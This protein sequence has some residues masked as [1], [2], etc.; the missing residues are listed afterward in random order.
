MP[1]TLE[2]PLAIGQG[3]SPLLVTV[4]AIATGALVANLYYAQPLIASIAPELGIGP[5]LAGSIVSV[6]QIGYGLGLFL[7]VSLADLIENKT[8]V[9]V[10]LACTTLGLIGAALSTATVPFFVAAFLI[11]LCSTGAQVLIPFMAHLV[12]IERR[13]RMVGNV[14]AGLLTGIMLARPVA[15]F[16]AASFGWRAVFWSSAV[17]M[18]AIGAALARLM[19]T[20]KPESRM[21]Y[22]QIL[23]SMAGLLR[24]LP[25]LR[26]R[27]VYQALMFAAFNMFWTAAPLMLAERFGLGEYG[28]GLFALAGA[29]GALAAPLAGRFADSGHMRA[30]TAGA[31]IMLGLGFLA[32]GWAAAAA[33]LGT[34]AVLAI[35]IDAAVQ[36]NQVVSQRIIF[37]VPSEVRGRVNA[38]YMTATFIGGALGSLAGS[39]T[40][41]WGGWMATA[42]TGGLMGALALLLFGVE[43][44]LAASKAS[45]PAR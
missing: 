38:L 4:I 43:Q 22:G 14:M 33:A 37:S 16:I 5:D 36:G 1:K 2:D 34:L 8:L 19:P 44:G 28:I 15:L 39:I 10:T 11:G 42:A 32:T 21:H 41:H 35:L 17:L 45:D 6:T 27:A 31:M 24:K 25:F 40:Y 23:V 26:W 29:G 7:L 18:M 30:A 13:G 20:H 9:L 12:P 3:P